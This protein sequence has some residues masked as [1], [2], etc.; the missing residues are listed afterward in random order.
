MLL[1]FPEPGQRVPK[2]GALRK[3]RPTRK[4]QHAAFLRQARKRYDELLERQGNVCAVCKRAP[5][6]DQKRR[7]HVDHDHKTMT[8]RGVVCFRCNRALPSWVTPE[9][10]RAAAD[11][12]EEAA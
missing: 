10:L 1:L 7:F 5:N 2:Y 6:P 9:W 11:Y 12:L 3:P 4:Q 8:V